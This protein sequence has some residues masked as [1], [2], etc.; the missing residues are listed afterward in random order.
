MNQVL[1]LILVIDDSEDDNFFHNRAIQKAG[2]CE[3]VEVAYTGREA[4][5]FL[6]TPEPDGQTPRPDLIFLDINMPEM[7][8]WEFL[9]A[10]QAR[11]EL[12][13][14]STPLIMLTNSL[15]KLDAQNGN[16]HPLVDLFLLKPLEAKTVK[17]VVEKFFG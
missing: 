3:H 5:A 16:K 2:V 1:K 8:G 15:N 4:L 6:T 11:P 14:A 9:D 17:E 12:G 10:C 7:N 13:I